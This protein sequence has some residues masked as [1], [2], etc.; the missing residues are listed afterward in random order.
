MSILQY[1]TIPLGATQIEE[2]GP[3]VKKFITSIPAPRLAEESMSLSAAQS[4]SPST[5]KPSFTSILLSSAV[6]LSNMPETSPRDGVPLMSTRESLSLQATTV[7]FRRFVSKSGPIFWLQ[8]RI[9]EVL[10]WKRG[11]KITIMWMAIYALFCFFP[12][13]FLLLP[14]IILISILLANSN[15]GP[16]IALDTSYI[17]QASQAQQPKEGTVDW[18][19]NLQ[20]IQNLMG[21]VSDGYDIVVQWVPLLT[22]HTPYTSQLLTV[23]CVSFLFCVPIA[24]YVPLR[25]ILLFLGL[26]PFLITHP[27]SSRILQALVSPYVPT[28][29]SN[30]QRYIDNDNLLEKHWDAEKRDVE[31]WENERWESSV[32]WSKSALRPSEKAWTSNGQWGEVVKIDN[33]SI[34]FA[35][36]AQYR[37]IETENWRLGRGE[38]VEASGRDN[39]AWVYCDDTWQSRSSVESKTQATTRKRRWVRRIYLSQS[40]ET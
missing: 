17:M 4:P 3:N 27:I 14:H 9:E 38:A 20:A 26:A 6:N 13:M 16:P 18:Y 10:L 24:I 25:P 22:W 21:T 35:L 31:L 15:A 1:A 11:W 29:H 37:F 39:S 19:A 34:S 33:G 5:S 23:L 12:R 36:P 2:R 8:D 30:A 32:G 7:N 40:L 28:W